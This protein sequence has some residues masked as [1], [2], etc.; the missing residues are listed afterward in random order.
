VSSPSNSGDDAPP[1]AKVET[2]VVAAKSTK[3][4]V[5]RMARHE[6]LPMPS[7]FAVNPGVLVCQRVPHPDRV[8]SSSFAHDGIPRTR[9]APP[10]DAKTLIA[11]MEKHYSVK[12]PERY[13]TFLS[14]AEHEKHPRVKFS[15]YHR[16]PYDLDFTSDL[17][18][19]VAEL[20]MNAG[21]SDMDDVPWDED[22][23]AY[24][25]LA[26]LSHPEVDEPKM[27]LVLDVKSPKH[28]VLLFA[29]E[30]WKL[31][32]IAASFDAFLAALPEAKNDISKSFRPGEDSDD[33]E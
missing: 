30:G 26:E 22:Y 28:P 14:N 27:F 33:D 19:D 18:A 5:A 12:L 17:L 23:A 8:C 9:Y 4:K 15:G 11:K 13:K 25:P 2:V 1:H 6:A 29:Q 16:G 32:P 20:G 3:I 10:M 7:R 24:V 31:Y 21:I